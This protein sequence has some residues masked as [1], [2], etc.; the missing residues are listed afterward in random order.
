MKTLAFIC[1]LLFIRPDMS[2]GQPGKADSLDFFRD[3]TVVEMKLSTDFKKLRASNKINDYQPATVSCLI[4]DSTTTETIRLCARGQYRRKNCYIP[5]IL[6]DFKNTSSPKLSWLGKLKLV[7]GCATSSYN[8]QLLLKEWLVYKIYNLITDKSFRVR[9]LKITYDDPKKKIKTFTQY[10]FVMEDAKDVAKRN[11]CREFKKTKIKTENT[12]RQQM[13]IV[14]LF[15]YMIG[16]TDWTVPGG[17]N[18]RLI[19]L[20]KDSLSRPFVIPYDFDYSGLVDANYAIPAE[21]LGTTSVTERVYRGFPRTMGE[22]EIALDIFRQQED[23]IYSLIKNF[24]A[25]DP[26]HQKAMITY[27]YEFYSL[28]KIKNMVK[29]TFIDGARTE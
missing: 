19:Q 20:K 26:Y 3:E 17:H 22:L 8:E 1:L 13:T 23:S 7:S 11:K 9:L 5:T 2:L 16:N 24:K 25:L 6:L 29:L 21:A 10:A 28:I 18:I 15:Q 4:K 14:A 12:D 27:L